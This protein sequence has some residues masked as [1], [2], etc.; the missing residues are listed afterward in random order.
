VEYRYGINWQ[1]EGNCGVNDHFDFENYKLP[2]EMLIGKA[3]A[4][5]Q[6]R[7]D[8]FVKLPMWWLEK[9]RG[10]NSASTFQVAWCL[11][12]LNYRNRGRPFKLPNGMLG[13]YGVSPRSKWRALDD[14]GRHGLIA[15]VE[16]RLRKSPIIQVHVDPPIGADA[17]VA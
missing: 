9:L 1:T 10:C 7:R 3:P 8:N 13:Y 2:P 14:L 12:Y 5:I 11:L 4:K 6:K 17:Y 15:V 16:R